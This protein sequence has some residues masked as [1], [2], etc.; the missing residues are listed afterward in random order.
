VDP[1]RRWRIEADSRVGILV[2]EGWELRIRPH[3]EIPKLLFL[4]TYSLRPEGWEG[5][6]TG[7][8][9]ERDIV[10]A[11]ASGFCLHAGRIID[12]GLLRGYVTV[13][14]RRGD[15][16]GRTRFKDQLARLAGLAPPLEVAYDDFTPDIPENR[17][18]RAATEK[19]LTLERVSPQS[20]ARL[21]RLRAALE[22][23]SVPI[24]AHRVDLPP[25][26]RL[27]QSYEAALILAKLIL[28]GTSLSQTRGAFA[29]RSFLFDMNEVFESFLYRALKDCMRKSGGV[30][31]RQVNGALDRATKPGLPLRADIVWRKHGVVRAV[32]DSKYKALSLRGSTPNEDAYQMLAYC[33]AFGVQRGLLVYARDGL[34]LP[35]CHEVRRHGYEI[36]VRSVSVDS[37]PDLLLKEVERIAAEVVARAPEPAAAC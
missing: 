5:V 15:L 35:R 11:L 21:C 24:V 3:I 1:P 19:L 31:Q 10:Q 30:V 26:T 37:Q 23:V 2:G 6:L 4:L 17:L 29:A 22:Q 8:E 9:S 13:E 7:M 28:D 25:I 32:I 36:E 18:L 34:D 27:N 12:Q 14:E 16:R 33:I 20:R